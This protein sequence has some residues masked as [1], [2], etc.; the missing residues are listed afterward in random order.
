MLHVRDGR[1]E[2][3]RRF[4]QKVMKMNP[5]GGIATIIALSKS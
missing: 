3:E 5:D 2:K 1:G 4:T